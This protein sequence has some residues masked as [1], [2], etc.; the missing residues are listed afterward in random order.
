MN[1][2]GGKVIEKPLNRECGSEEQ[3]QISTDS[4][5]RLCM[6]IALPERCL[7]RLKW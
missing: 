2:D 1:G 3:P 4:P 6:I 7:E 5:A